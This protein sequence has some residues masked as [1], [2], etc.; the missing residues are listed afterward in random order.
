MQHSEQSEGG[1]IILLCPASHTQ[2]TAVPGATIFLAS[3]GHSCT[4]SPQGL[5][6]LAEHPEAT[7]KCMGCMSEHEV[8]SSQVSSVPG[9]IEAAAQA[10]G[11]PADTFDQRLQSLTRWHGGSVV[12]AR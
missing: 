8:F 5:A 3:C 4:I 6:A 11:I 12:Q 1:L 9:G 2:A 7:T 10:T